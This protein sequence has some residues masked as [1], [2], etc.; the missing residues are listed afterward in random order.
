MKTSIGSVIFQPIYNLRL[1][2]RLQR[3]SQPNLILHAGL[4]QFRQVAA[5]PFIIQIN[6]LYLYLKIL[7]VILY[8]IHTLNNNEKFPSFC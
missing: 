8:N 3:L 4:Q 7:Q 1:Q 5:M 2:I 6:M